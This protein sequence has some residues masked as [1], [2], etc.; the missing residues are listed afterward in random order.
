M[1]LR[2][3]FDEIVAERERQNKK[4]P[5]EAQAKLR[6]GTWY[7]ILG[8]EVG[9]IAR[10][11]LDNNTVAQQANV[12]AYHDSEH[13]RT[14]LVQAAAVIAAW[15]TFLSPP[16]APPIDIN[17]LMSSNPHEFIKS[18]VIIQ[19]KDIN[20]AYVTVPVWDPKKAVFV[21]LKN[22][23]AAV[24]EK[25]YCGKQMIAEVNI[26]VDDAE[27]LVFKEWRTTLPTLATPDDLIE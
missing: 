2:K 22:L 9:E 8:E 20:G 27:E 14:E 1:S 7:T 12:T 4:F 25:M 11:L 23:P 16:E 6:N 18:L 19:R 13:L 21:P 3:F 10:D 24:H 26:F 5:D 15:Y 17:K